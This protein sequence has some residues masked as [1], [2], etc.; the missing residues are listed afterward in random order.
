MSNYFLITI[1]CYLRVTSLHLVVQ[2][3]VALRS[4]LVDL[5]VPDDWKIGSNSIV[6][7]IK[8]LEDF[9]YNDAW[10]AFR[11]ANN[12]EGLDVGRIVA[13]YKD[14]Y[15]VKTSNGELDA[16]LIGHLRYA[17]SQRDDLPSVGDWVALA[18]YD[19]GKALIHAVYPRYSKI[20]RQAIGKFGEKQIIAS[21]IDYAFVVQSPHRDFNVN[22][23]ER[24]VSLCHAS[25]V[26][27]IV[28]LNKVDLLDGVEIQTL[29][30]VLQERV[31]DCPVLA[32]SVSTGYGMDDVKSL[33]QAGKTYCLLGSSGV[34]KSTLL[35]ALMGKEWMETGEISKSID[36]GKHITSHREMFFLENGGIIIDNPGLREVGII[37][38]DGAVDATFGHI[39]TLARSCKFKDC[40]HT[41][42]TGCAVLDALAKGSLN[43]DYYGNYLRLKREE[44]HFTADIHEKKRKEKGFGVMRKEVKSF[45]RKYKY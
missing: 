40:S 42:E 12:L 36:R 17:V 45:K 3:L 31:G 38:A 14:R 5:V 9:G 10:K 37:D 24:Y 32:I 15:R 33:I 7:K 28:L 44:A 35:N 21:N 23:I 26:E 41:V 39:A 22:R 18:E 30:D 16:E 8:K 29:L 43:P 20:E 27:P 34:G 19:P 11:V 4:L 25:G 13:E 2:G 6:M 1:F